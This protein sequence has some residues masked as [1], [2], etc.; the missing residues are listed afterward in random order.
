MDHRAHVGPGPV[1]LGVDVVFERRACGAFDQ[2]PFEGDADDVRR[3]QPRPGRGSGVDVERSVVPPCA[4]VA[5]V[6]DLSGL[7]EHPD[8][9]DQLAFQ[10][11]GLRPSVHSQ[12]STE[13]WIAPGAPCPPTDLMARSTCASP[14]RCVVM[15]S[16]G[17]RF[18][19]RW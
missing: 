19:P 17:N 10:L 1:D 11:L 7:L 8:G 13:T 12:G 4:A 6:V 3:G 18:E 9:I 16:I 2:L 15:S 14:N 5:A